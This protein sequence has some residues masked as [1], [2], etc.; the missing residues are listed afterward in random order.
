[1]R[2]VLFAAAILPLAALWMA[3]S[4]P[5]IS[6]ADE[7]AIRATVENYFAGMMQGRA[8]LLTEAFHSDAR[9]IGVG[10]E[11][12]ALVLPVDRWAQGWEG[13]SP[14]DL[15]THRNVILSVDIHGDAA[16]VKTDLVWPNVRY[17]DYLSLLKLDGEWKIVNKIW[18]Q[19]QP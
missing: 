10:Q 19:E 5:A 7:D 9:L 8:E 12:E 4:P 11:G 14:R 6:S 13:R 1:M 17:I 2:N 3:A 16:M 18:A 15:S